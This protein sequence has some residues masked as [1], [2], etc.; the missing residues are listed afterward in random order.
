MSMRVALF[1]T[2]LGD[3]FF[4]DSV[5][6][7]VRLLRHLGAEVHYP[8]GQTC[9]G[10]PAFNSGHMDEARRAAMHTVRTFDGADYVV[11][12]SGSCAGM[13]RQMYPSLLG[14]PAAPLAERTF[15]LAQFITQVLGVQD[16]GDGLQGRHIAYHHG[17]HALRELGIEDEPVSLLSRAGASVTD[18]E[19][20]QECCGF[21]GLFSVKIP[22]VS[23][24]MADRKLD[25]L[26]EVD[27]ITSADGGCLMQ[28]SGRARR[29]KA[30][31]RFRHLASVL[32]EATGRGSDPTAGAAL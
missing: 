3:S 20:D 32:W 18:W 6:D 23:V 21:G 8:E 27:F 11:L 28:M 2:C 19:A 17:C 31:V 13:L 14:E 9:C 16:L 30:A 12:P 15:E 26:P 24:A 7:A 10:Q 29:R 1:A 5:A 22:E 4:A 25:S